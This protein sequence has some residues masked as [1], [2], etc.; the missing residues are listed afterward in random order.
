LNKAGILPDFFARLSQL[1][2]LVIGDLMLDH[3]L[4]GRVER[5]SPEAP[6]PVVA[7][8]REEYRLGGAANVAL[9]L[10]ALGT[11]P[12][13]FG[14]VGQDARAD[15]FIN[16]LQEQAP[17]THYLFQDATRPTTT[18]TRVMGNGRQQILR[19]DTEVNTPLH[20]TVD[21]ELV[22][23][24]TKPHALVFED[25]DKGLITPTLIQEV[26]KAN[27][28]RGKRVPI[29]VDPKRKNFFAYTGVDVFKPN[30]DELN[31]AM[32]LHLSKKD[33]PGIIQAVVQLR[34]TMPHLH[35]LITLSEEGML[36]VDEN[37]QGHPIAGHIRK[38]HDVSGAGDTVIAVMAAGMAAGL[39]LPLS[40]ALA[41]IAG[42]LVCEEIG[43]A[44]IALHTLQQEIT[45][46]FY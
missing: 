35:T 7:F 42:G 22:L 11:Q 33:I 27:Q 45:N 34:Q 13:L 40:V 21:W 10:A 5:I 32:G 23:Q 41:N 1:R 18:K 30:L 44:P 46:L 38:V 9:N 19:I 29:L 12:I 2:I 6:V 14:V 17:A 15:I 8:E 4:W 39:A 31:T 26:L 43:V 36:L 28:N 3:Y 25:Y 37:L 20:P 24:S 16:L